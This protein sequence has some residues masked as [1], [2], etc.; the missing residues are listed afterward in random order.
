MAVA[1]S[2]GEDVENILTVKVYFAL[3]PSCVE[4]VL[5]VP[6][7]RSYS[8]FRGVR[9]GSGNTWGRI[10][11]VSWE[12][13]RSYVFTASKRRLRFLYIVPFLKWS[14]RYF[15]WINLH[16]LADLNTAWQIMYRT[17]DKTGHFLC[18]F[19]TVKPKVLLLE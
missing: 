9:K 12:L 8:S 6:E 7:H 17:T 10:S 13:S 18:N 11:E 16:A 2:R 4:E 1:L 19:Y 15:C 14:Q 5:Y 3:P